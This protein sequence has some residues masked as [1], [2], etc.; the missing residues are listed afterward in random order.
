MEQ[1]LMSTVVKIY[2]RNLLLLMFKAKLTNVDQFW[3][4]FT[5]KECLTFLASSWEALNSSI[6]RKAWLL[7][8]DNYCDTSDVITVKP[9]QN[10]T[11]FFNNLIDELSSFPDDICDKL[12]A[13]LSPG[14]DYLVR[15]LQKDKVIIVKWFKIR[16]D[17]G[18]DPL[19]DEEI[20]NMT[21]DSKRRDEQLNDPLRIDGEFEENISSMATENCESEVTFDKSWMNELTD[22]NDDDGDQVTSVEALKSLR[23]VKKWILSCKKSSRCHQHFVAELEKLITQYC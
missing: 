3:N 5:L 11:V 19:T 2:K 6:L 9:N 4:T 16:D 21:L 7:F 23:K 17:F 20:I 13:R 15:K 14:A 10:T 12:I 1:G 18:W 8:L 22:V